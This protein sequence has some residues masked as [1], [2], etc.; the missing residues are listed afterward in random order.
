MKPHIKQFF[1]FLENKE[2][3]GIPFKVKVLNPKDFKLTPK[4]LNIKGHL[5]FREYEYD[6]SDDEIRFLNSLPD[7]LTVGKNLYLDDSPIKSLP[8]NLTVK[9]DLSLT[10]T[11]IEIDFIPNNL[12]VRGNLDLTDSALSEKYTEEEIR[13]AIEKKGGFVKGDIDLKY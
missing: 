4:D 8:N 2:G 11:D 6:L 12:K 7:N 9:G 13:S 3:K 5:D 10:F 1:K